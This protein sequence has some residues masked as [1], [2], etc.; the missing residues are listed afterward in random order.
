[1]W[2]RKGSSFMTVV[3]YWSEVAGRVLRPQTLENPAY[4]SRAGRFCLSSPVLQTFIYLFFPYNPSIPLLIQSE[5]QTGKNQSCWE[6][7][8]HSDLCS[9]HAHLM[10]ELI[11]NHTPTT[12]LCFQALA[13][14]FLKTPFNF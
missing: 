9:D 3:T 11:S 8:G 10:T 14:F 13:D 5:L 1:M 2:G 6:P 4:V 7:V 12:P